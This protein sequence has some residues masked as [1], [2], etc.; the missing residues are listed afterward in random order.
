MRTI[1]LIAI[2]I[3]LSGCTAQWHIKQAVKKDA[4]IFKRTSD[5]SVITKI[6]TQDTVIIFN[7]DERIN[8]VT[9]TAFE[10]SGL[11]WIFESENENI[12]TKIERIRD[13]IKVFVGVDTVL[14]LK[15]SVRLQ[16]RF[17]DRQKEIITS[18][19]VE[20]TE[21]RSFASK[22]ETWVTIAGVIVFI[23]VILQIYSYFKK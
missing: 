16:N 8:F 22:L 9:D 17:I 11:K 10:R 18:R 7:R 3:L 12:K 23:L 4:E 1:I 15:D 6:S 20:I 19:E 14:T 2:T 21:I 5:T 13:T